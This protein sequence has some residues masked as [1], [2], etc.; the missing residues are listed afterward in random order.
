MKRKFSIMGAV[1]TLAM[2]TACTSTQ[3]TN[4]V[5]YTPGTITDPVK[6]MEVKRDLW[7]QKEEI[8]LKMEADKKRAEEKAR[9]IAE[10]AKAAEEKAKEEARIA[11]EKAKEE[12]R[13]AQERAEEEARVAAAKAKAEADRIAAE[14]KAAAL[15][16]EQEKIS[17]MSDEE[18]IEY[19]INSFYA[20]LKE[21][22]KK[23][24]ATRAKRI[25]RK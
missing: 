5:E 18:Y 1:C 14:K 3:T 2:M 22:D 6:L 8:R 19:K 15:K 11:A 13:L 21:M 12:A 9:I 25:N 10:R 4:R 20:K 16:A 24:E 17:K 23:V 7:K